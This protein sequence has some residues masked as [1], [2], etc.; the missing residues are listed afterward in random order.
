[1]ENIV[2]TKQCQNCQQSFNVTDWDIAF[3]DKVA[4]V[5]GEQK[6]PMP[7]PTLCQPCRSQ[8][9]LLQVNQI[10]LYPRTCDATGE[11][12]ICN[13]APESEYKVYKQQYWFSDNWDARSYGKEYDFNR[14]FFE[15]YLELRKEVPRPALMTDFLRDE[16]SAYTNYAGLNKD[17]Y[18]IFD[19]DEN[20]DCFYSYGQN[21][22]KNSSDCYRVGNLELCYENIDCN[23]NYGCGFLQNSRNCN[24]SYFLKNC[25]ACKHCITCSN[26]DHK[27]YHIFNK[28]VSKEEYEKLRKSLKSYENVQKYIKEFE[29]FKLQFPQKEDYGFQN[30]NCSGNYLNNCKNAHS[31]YDSRNL[32]DGK[33]CSQIFLNAKD[34]MDCDEVGECELAYESNNVGFNAYMTRFSLNCL[35]KLNDF[36]YCDFCNHSSNLFGCVGIRNKSYCILNKQ[37][38]KEQYEE[39]LPKVIEHMKSTNEWGEY[40]PAWT[41]INP[42]NISMGQDHFPLSKEEALAKGY[43]WK[44]EDPKEH[45]AQTYDTPDNI[46][47]VTEEICSQILAC[48]NCGKNYKILSQELELYKQMGMPVPRRCFHCRHFGRTALRN[49]RTL[50][51]RNCDKCQ[52]PIE[53]TYSPERPEKVYCEKCYLE[54]VY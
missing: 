9:K 52:A 20:R 21:S 10:Y 44:E 26:L 36:S 32:W 13:Y 2:E 28:P 1:M 38:T 47:D 33:Y 11:N 17:C 14:P 35:D 22:C 40:F 48:T 30:E 27:E 23:N 46:D 45:Q 53:T 42:Y 15:Q 8:R 54:A 51:N 24:D 49:P 19:S 50:W 25:T 12:I 18:L 37:Y 43:T 31:C 6:F 3:Y 41:S 7:S 34:C 5:V 29:T 4:V 16:N 39:L